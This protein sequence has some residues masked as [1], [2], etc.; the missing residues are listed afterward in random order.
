MIKKMSLILLVSVLVNHN[1]FAI[2]L[3][4]ALQQAYLNNPEL[5]AERENIQVSKE[6][7][8]ISRSEFLPTITLSGSKSR[9]N[10]EKLTDRNGAN[11]AITDVDPKSQSIVIEQKIFQG[12]AGLAGIEKSKI[13]INLADA[14]LLK[15]DQTCRYIRLFMFK[16]ATNWGV[17]LWEIR[18]YGFGDKN[19]CRK[20]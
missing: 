14:K 1:G 20:R 16:P 12:F 2:T 19:V 9:E 10:T 13:G 8:N 18:V 6:D 7:L 5:N 3:S 11:S 17:S 4:E 15:T